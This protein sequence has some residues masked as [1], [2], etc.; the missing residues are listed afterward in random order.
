MNTHVSKKVFLRIQLVS[1]LTP[2]C[3]VYNWQWSGNW[4][5]DW[6]FAG[7]FGCFRYVW[8][9]SMNGKLYSLTF[10]LPTNLTVAIHCIIS[11]MIFCNMILAVQTIRGKF[12]SLASASDLIINICQL[13]STPIHR[14]GDLNR[15]LNII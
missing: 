3:K 2:H 6:M 11:I 13:N 9:F 4:V 7:V 12:A 14:E 8:L 15:S 1:T 5:F 10:N